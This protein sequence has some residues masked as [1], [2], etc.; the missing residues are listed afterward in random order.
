MTVLTFG[1]YRLDRLVSPDGEVTTE[2]VEIRPPVHYDSARPAP[3]TEVRMQGLATPDGADPMHSPSPRETAFTIHTRLSAAVLPRYPPATSTAV[4]LPQVFNQDW[5]AT[6]PLPTHEKGPDQTVALVDGMDFHRETDQ[7]AITAAYLDRRRTRVY[8]SIHARSDGW[9]SL[10]TLHMARMLRRR[11]ICTMYE[12][13]A[14][15]R[16]L[17]PHDDQ[18]FGVILQM[19]GAKAWRLWPDNGGSPYTVTTRAGDVLLLP[20]G[21]KHQ[22]ATPNY[23]VHLVLAVTDEP[24]AATA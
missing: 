19:K 13:Q 16:N 24:L 7:A 8:E 3:G 12:S 14:A 15:D 23:S 4:H 5:I 6:L 2:R 21:V 22:V 9:F 17:G 10:V 20:Q 1:F 18:W 11:I